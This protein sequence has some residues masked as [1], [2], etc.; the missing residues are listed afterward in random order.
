MSLSRRNFMKCGLLTGASVALTACQRNVEHGLVSQY[1]M[2]EY[3]LTAQHVYTATTCGECSGGCG[4]A[5]KT[6]DGRAI[7]MDGLPEHPLSRGKV[8]ARGQSS[9]QVAYHPSRLNNIVDAKGTVLE[10]DWAKFFAGNLEKTKALADRQPLFVTRSLKGTLGG[11]MVELAKETGGKIWVVDY[12]SRWAERQ[13]IKSLTGKAELPHYELEKADYVVTFGGDLLSLGHNSVHANWGYGQFRQGLGRE[14]G[15]LVSVSSRINMTAANSDR[16]LPVRPGTE[17]W[18]ALAVGNI[19]AAKGKGPWPAWAKSVSLEKVAEV[20]Q[21]DAGLIEK[22]ADRLAAAKHPLI[23][24]DS[25]AGNYVNGI[26]SLWAIHA[27]QK[28]LTGSITTFEPENVLGVKGGVP[29]DLLVN[30]QGAIKHLEGGNCGAI[31]VFD[32]DI[33]SLLPSALN[34]PDLIKKGGDLTV[35]STFAN[36]T[37]ALAKTVVPIYNWLE[38]FGD[39][40]IT[41]PGTDVYNV[42]QPVITPLW[43][44]ARSLG[45]I[46]TAIKLGDPIGLGVIP[47]GAAAGAAKGKTFRELIR[48]D[49]SDGHWETQ[50]ARGGSYSPEGLQWDIYKHRAS[51]PPPLLADPGKAPSGV[52][53]YDSMEAAKVTGWTGTVVDGPVLLPFATLAL[54]DGSLGNR[55]W[56][57]EL[58]D[59]VTTIVWGPWIEM[60]SDVAAEKGIKRHDVV[61]VTLEGVAEPIVGPAFPLPSLHPDAIAIPVGQENP[62]FSGW[63][64][65]DYGLGSK[66]FGR[67]GWT[68]ANYGKGGINPLSKV[69]AEMTNAGE[70]KWVGHKVT[71]VE[72]LNKTEMITAMD[73]RVFELPRE[74]LPF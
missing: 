58:P 46:L 24:A 29:K 16:W 62:D 41:G 8:C 32:V 17:G 73:I 31:W 72:K 36:Q 21:L 26:E 25:D 2:P 67:Y 14:R 48:G 51:A 43:G 40:R 30:T 70:P 15:I 54:R 7:K 38:D 12:P 1:Q 5:I 37:T 35:F 11:L 13:V 20:T 42:Q 52:N 63:S 3:R 53:P 33:V 34:V 23:V 45:D 56:M 27:L 68:N 60:N 47:E 22:L 50:L 55:P 18:V 4:V 39:Q 44:G 66:V 49:A 19:L 71:K 6:I 65:L 28:M 57:Q 59:P 64:G 9:L 74:I 10:R 61:S 69:K